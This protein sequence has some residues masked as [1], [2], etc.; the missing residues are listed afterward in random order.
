MVTMHSVSSQ[1]GAQAGSS[2]EVPAARGFARGEPE[3]CRGAG[4][5]QGRSHKPSEGRVAG[6]VPDPRGHSV[7]A[8]SAGAWVTLRCMFVL[9]R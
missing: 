1:R 7:R 4:Q 6:T 5:E 2:S 8:V 9:E 3:T